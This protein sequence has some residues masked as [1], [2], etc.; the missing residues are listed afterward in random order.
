MI[1][2]AFFRLLSLLSLLA[3]ILLSVYL[4][5]SHLNHATQ[6]PGNN[7]GASSN[8]ING[9]ASRVDNFNDQSQK[10]L[11]QVQSQIGR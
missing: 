3:G 5:V 6:I 4:Y 10:Q 8:P 7:K 9:A 1:M 2:G 11:Q